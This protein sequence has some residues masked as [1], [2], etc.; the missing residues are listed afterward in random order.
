MENQNSHKKYLWSI[1]I[2]ILFLSIS[3]MPL[4][5]YAASTIASGTCN[6]GIDWKLDSDYT[7]HCSATASG[8]LHKIS[9]T[10]WDSYRDQI[11]KVVIGDEIT[12]IGYRA[13]KDYTSLEKVELSSTVKV[14]DNGAFMGCEKLSEI[15]FPN[16]LTTISDNT[17]LNCGLTSITINS[18]KIG[19]NAFQGCQSLKVVLIG[20]GVSQIAANVF[21]YCTSLESIDVNDNNKYYSSENGI[22]FNK[23]KSILMRYPS[24]KTGDSYT[25]PDS[26]TELAI[27]AFY[28]NKYLKSVTL[29]SNV[30][31]IGTYCFNGCTLLT[32]VELPCEITALPNG[33][34]NNCKSLNSITIPRTVSTIG[35]NAF[36]NCSGLD[37]VYFRGDALD[38][39]TTAFTN[40]DADAFYPE[41]NTTWTEE[42][43][44]SYSG[45]LEWQAYEVPRTDI[46]SWSVTVQN[47]NAF[48]YDGTE[49]KPAVVVKNGTKQMSKG[50][51]YTVDYTD[52][53]FPGT[54]SVIVTG[55]GDYQGSIRANFPIQK[56]TFQEEKKAYTGKW[57]G[58]P[59]TFDDIS[60]TASTPITPVIYYSTE[61]PLTEDNYETDG[62]LEKPE[63]TSPGQSKVY[64]FITDDKGYYNPVTGNTTI[65]VR[66]TATAASFSG[67]YDG[68]AHSAT[69]ECCEGATLYYSISTPLTYDNYT[70]NGSTTVPKR[71][72]AGKTTVYYIAVPDSDPADSCVET[73]STTITIKKA[74]Q[75]INADISSGSLLEGETAQITAS[76][77]A[78]N[79]SYESAN[80]DIATVNEDGLV[81]AVSEGTTEIIVTAAATTNYN[82][83]TVRIPVEVTALIEKSIAECE[84]AAISDYIYIGREI[85][86]KIAITDGEYT[87]KEDKDYSVKYSNNTN[88]GT[89]RITISG[90][91]N[92]VGSTIK[93]FKI[94]KATQNLQFNVSATTIRIGGTAEI[95]L[96]NQPPGEVT[97]ASNDRNIAT[98]TKSGVVK[99]VSKGS[100]NVTV[101]AAETDN[102][103]QAVRT[104]AINVEEEEVQAKSLLDCEIVLSADTYTYDGDIK[105][106]M[107]TVKD[108]SREL[109]EGE[110]YTLAYPDNMR[111]AG[112]LKITI[113]GI[114]VYDGSKELTYE[115]NPADP[116]LSFAESSITKKTYDGTFVNTLQAVTDGEITYS[117]SDTSVARINAE[118][119][120]VRITGAGSATITAN[121]SQ[122]RNYRRGSRSYQLTVTQDN[123]NKLSIDDFSYSFENNSDFFGYLQ[124]TGDKRNIRHSVVREMYGDM[125]RADEIYKTH[126]LGKDWNGNCAGFSGT[127]ALLT[128]SSSG[129][130][131][132]HFN[133]RINS[134]GGLSL[135]DK[136]YDFS[137]MTVKGFIESMQVGHYSQMFQKQ[138]EL[139][140]VYTDKKKN[141]GNA[142]LNTFYQEVKNE[143]D[144]GRP[145][146]LALIQ[147]LDSG[148]AVL[149]YDTVDSTIDENIPDDE[150]W[151]LLYDSN[152]AHIQRALVLK[153]NSHGDF[154]EWE[155]EM[156]SGLGVWGTA[157]SQS[158]ISYIPYQTIKRI[159]NSRGRL[160]EEED[161]FSTDTFNFD[162][163]NSN[164]NLVATIREGELSTKNPDIYLVENLWVDE[165]N[166]DKLVL[167]MPVGTYKFKNLDEKKSDFNV[168]MV[169]NDL[170]ISVSTTSGE[171]TLAVDDEKHRNAAYINASQDD[172][173]SVTLNSTF[174]SDDRNVVVSG[175]GTGQMAEISQIKG[176]INIV[177]C[178]Y[179]SVSVNGKT[180][181]K[182]CITALSE[183]G[184]TISP[185]GEKYVL[186]G[187]KQT[188]KIIPYTGYIIA[189][190]LV[191]GKSV[192]AVTTYSFENVTANH[193]IKARFEK[194]SDK[195]SA[196]KQNEIIAKD[197]I[198]T[199]A[200]KAKT[201]KLVVKAQDG[202]KLS[203]Q[204]S[205]KSIKVNSSGTV[206]IPKN[207]VG[208]ARIIIK[209]AATSQYKE[210]QKTITITINPTGT[211]LK[212]VKR[213]GSGKMTIT[214]KRNAK[215]SGYEICLSQSA[216]FKKVKTRLIKKNKTE[217]AVFKKL[218]KG[219]WY[220]RIRTYKTVMGKRYYSSWSKGKKVK[221]R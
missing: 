105:K 168:S 139:H 28:E 96:T 14:L 74:D 178:D 9:V 112:N 16:S 30:N 211:A 50:E 57:D 68:K 3:W 108:G 15:N 191:D 85:E 133:P 177:N 217:K 189:D 101:M 186:K 130:S 187:N 198:L 8:T 13:F 221:I 34:F 61:T 82:E 180:I 76:A 157:E 212:K 167:S 150:A 88:A 169:N 83:K 202:A 45:S 23:N 151:I 152:C 199:T 44:G 92:Y 7:L 59:H 216:K 107:V 125:V 201:Y 4:K 111:D 174:S 25:M 165:N 163:Y 123:K 46:S 110:D 39:N 100:V 179:D 113:S 99:G 52:N 60:I 62:T 31:E 143:T 69:V 102:Y 119:G 18:G 210:A 145:V 182:Y 197:V 93:T 20:S 176:S 131:V 160:K 72:A 184:G 146:V 22:L 33:C 127:A 220:V 80:T 17:F 181:P 175:T 63:R 136:A 98:V 162:V 122:G 214:W 148:H 192:G 213:S 104:V 89:A 5:V 115:I 77:S 205:N 67:T 53:I 2:I 158:S 109:N 149:A 71:F 35:D 200:A 40:V 193:S 94:N 138:L 137:D 155:Y 121:A 135:Y 190:V 54:A 171:V 114:G 38:I 203:F 78:G 207:Y 47:A 27:N 26:V 161:R 42:K 81:T 64:Y 91:G 208:S 140:R 185:Y 48:K 58:Q 166:K 204:S 117:S 215:V 173:Y 116:V 32:S 170:G 86:P 194:P 209:A 75:S 11:K 43:K 19:S 195:S 147:G 55:I 79:I 154:T 118:S 164:N 196:K 51:D 106:P 10:P 156:A 90:K 134:I 24:A 36:K 183:N 70:T 132:K 142:N 159:W 218:K 144:Q 21:P 41:N 120:E 95:T 153:R 219:K 141:R 124:E 1:W 37:S 206:T 6:T 29:S 73:G 56:G 97:F 129:I 87:L 12:E 128:D 126:F 103:Q 172:T 66:P 188:Y 49:H 65:T 84:I